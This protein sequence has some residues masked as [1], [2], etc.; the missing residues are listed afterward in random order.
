MTK[1]PHDFLD[2]IN[3]PVV[4]ALV[5]VMPDGSPQ[6]TPVWCNAPDDYIWINTARGRQKDRNM[7]PGAK[8]TILAIDP[9]NPY[10]WLEVRG[11]VADST[12]EGGV[13]HICALSALYRNEPDYYARNPAQQDRETRVIY[14]IAIDHVNAGHS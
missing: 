8:V 3:G 13:E 7:T 4:V 11:H 1:I 5:T 12:E 6:A 10:R 14:R 2:L 9:Q